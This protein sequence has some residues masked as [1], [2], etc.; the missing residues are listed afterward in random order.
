VESCMTSGNAVGIEASSFSPGVAA[1]V[2]VSNSTVT[3][4]TFG[5]EAFGNSI[6][7][8]RGNNTVEGNSVNTAGSIG[9]YTPR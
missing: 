2:R 5:L 9:S 6:I 1:T 8:S 7:L 4:N 3:D